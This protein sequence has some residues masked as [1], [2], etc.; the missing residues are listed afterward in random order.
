MQFIPFVRAFYAFESPLFYNHHNREG[1]VIII[2]STME[3]RQGDPLRG[4]L[5]AFTHFRTLHSITNHFLCLFPSIVD[6][7]HIIGP[8]SI[9][10]FTYEHFQ[11]EIYAIGLSIQ[12]HKCVAWSPFS[13]LPNFNTPS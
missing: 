5:F 12:L 1:D 7:T 2:P 13:L 8:P 10:S 6:D 11:I 3:T 4:A 9:V